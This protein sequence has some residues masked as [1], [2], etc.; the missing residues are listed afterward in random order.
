[1]KMKY[2]LATNMASIGKKE[3]P[4]PKPLKLLP[5]A[6]AIQ[7]TNLWVTQTL[8]NATTCHMHERQTTTG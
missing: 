6:A 8:F 2:R 7:Y 3:N 5:H 1:M 4:N